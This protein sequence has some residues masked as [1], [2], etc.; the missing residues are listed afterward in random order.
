MTAFDASFNASNLQGLSALRAAAD[1]P[2]AK[3]AVAKQFEGLFLNLMLKQMR[4]ASAIDG[5]LF[6]NQ[7]LELQQSMFDEQIA[8]TLAR[9]RGIGLADSILR[10]LGGDPGA[11]P[12]SNGSDVT[13]ATGPGIPLPLTGTSNATGRGANNDEPAQT[14]K[15]FARADRGRT[16]PAHTR[17]TFVQALWPHAEEAAKA[18][19][20][21]PDV[22][23]AQ[24]A[25]ETGWGRSQIRNQYGESALNVF[26]V[27]ANSDWRGPRA[28][29]ST[30]EFADGV[31]APRKEPF[32]MY[33]S[34][35]EAFDDYVGIIRG[36]ARYAPALD[37]G[38]SEHYIR[39]LQSAGYATDPDY[40]DKVIGILRRGLPGRDQVRPVPADKYDAAH[41]MA[42]GLQVDVNTVGDGS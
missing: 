11:L 16:L 17:E 29:V 40:A 36:R 31:M 21:S 25:L 42:A 10:S 32:R 12:T 20:T 22:L 38:S 35:G 26:G 3:R 14:D 13:L 30:L 24:A 34:L 2:D 7:R 33:S 23:V 37:A 9:G 39:A 4:S 8:L 28:V 18:L 5:G 1:T 6:D 41:K 19:G 27:K 15:L